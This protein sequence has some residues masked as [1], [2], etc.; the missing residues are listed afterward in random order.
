LKI[1][2]WTV[3]VQDRGGS[4][5]QHFQLKEVQRLEAEEV[6]TLRLFLLLAPWTRHQNITVNYP[7]SWYC[8]QWYKLLHNSTAHRGA[9][10]PFHCNKGYTKTPQ[11]YDIRTQPLLLCGMPTG[12]H[13]REQSMDNRNCMFSCSTDC[14]AVEATLGDTA[15]NPS[16]NKAGKRIETFLVASIEEGRLHRQKSR[17]YIELKQHFCNLRHFTTKH[18][19]QLG[20]GYQYHI[21]PYSFHFFL[22]YKKTILILLITNTFDFPSRQYRY[23]VEK[24]SLILQSFPHFLIFIIYFIFTHFINLFYFNNLFYFYLF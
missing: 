7:V 3:C 19:V 5:G 24:K 8:R 22:N 15:T 16:R 2:N 18:S 14:W 10:L 23:T 12:R 9:L 20:E 4:E 11:C 13:R 6:F 17:Q 1:Q 21:I